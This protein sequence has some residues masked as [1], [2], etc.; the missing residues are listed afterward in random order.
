MH[1][2]I[3]EAIA[4]DAAEAGRDPDDFADHLLALIDGC[5]VR[6]MIGDPAM[7]LDRMRELV[8]SFIAAELGYDPDPAL[9]AGAA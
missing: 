4:E 5:G 3:R 6:M 1:G 7:S 2:W 9:E 8:W